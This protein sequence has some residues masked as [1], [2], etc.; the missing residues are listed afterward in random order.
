MQFGVQKSSR[1]YDNLDYDNDNAPAST[2]NGLVQLISELF[3]RHRRCWWM[4]CAYPPYVV[5]EITS[6][7]L[8][9]RGNS[10]IDSSPHR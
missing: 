2:A 7:L 10:R 8:V 9:P 4:H 3:L 1:R 5:T 6:V